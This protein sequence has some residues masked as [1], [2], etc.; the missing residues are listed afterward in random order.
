MEFVS[1]KK[2]PKD[3]F[4]ITILSEKHICK[5]CEGVVEQFKKRYPNATVN[6]ISGKRGYNGDPNGGK[7]WTYRKKV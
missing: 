5:S 2:E 1:K 3:A 6:I 7:T 4:E